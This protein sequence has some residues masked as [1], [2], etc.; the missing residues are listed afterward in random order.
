[1]NFNNV[2][3]RAKLEN[4]NDNTST[5]L[6]LPKNLLDDVDTIVDSL[7]VT[8]STLFRGLL[9]EFV[10]T[11]NAKQDTKGETNERS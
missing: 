3:E 6:R 11:Y 7:G 2:V 5:T 10:S 1:M 9:I 4:Q 8:R